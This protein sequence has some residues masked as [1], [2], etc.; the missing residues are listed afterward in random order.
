MPRWT[1]Y[2]DARGEARIRA[3]PVVFSRQCG[4]TG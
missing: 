4:S 1:G 3:L 2:T